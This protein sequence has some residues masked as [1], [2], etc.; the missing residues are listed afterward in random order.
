MRENHSTTNDIG[1]MI[2]NFKESNTIACMSFSYVPVQD[3]LEDV[4]GDVVDDAVQFKFGGK[5][6]LLFPHANLVPQTCH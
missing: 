1:V 4:T 2:N 6:M 5:L 3:F